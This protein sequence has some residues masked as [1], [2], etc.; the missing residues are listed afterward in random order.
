MFVKRPNHVLTKVI[1]VQI[2]R[3]NYYLLG[4]LMIRAYDIT[5]K[6]GGY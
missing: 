2:Y 6:A 1:S 3:Q 5:G 4:G